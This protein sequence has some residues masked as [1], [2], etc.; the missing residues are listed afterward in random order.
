[1]IPIWTAE[2]TKKMAELRKKK[3]DMRKKKEEKANAAKEKARQL[4]Q[5]TKLAPKQNKKQILRRPAA[6]LA[7]SAAP[8]LTPSDG[9]SEELVVAM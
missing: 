2:Y 4:Q 5:K 8:R 7:A 9:G 3:E 6:A 1:M